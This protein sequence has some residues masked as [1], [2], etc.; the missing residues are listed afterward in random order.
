MSSDRTPLA[1]LRRDIDSIDDSMHDLLMRRAG[2]MDEIRRLKQG[3]GNMFFRPAREA[4]VL[5]RLLA[6]HRGA[7]PK[8]VLVRI[9]R[10]MMGALLCLQGPFAVALWEPEGGPG[11][12]AIAR[13]HFGSVTPITSHRSARA[14]INAVIENTVSVAVLPYPENDEPDPWWPLLADDAGWHVNVLGRLP[15]V[16]PETGGGAHPVALV[17][18]AATPEPTGSDHS[19]LLIDTVG[20]VSAMSLSAILR[21][22]DLAPCHLDTWTGTGDGQPPATLLLVDVADFV[23]SDDARLRRFTDEM[24]DVVRSISVAGAYASPLGAA[25]LA[26][27]PGEA[28]ETAP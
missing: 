13:D 22:V 19:L 12:R 17:V 20:T 5:R 6:R 14:A 28:K 8:P 18:G 11:Y 16:E 26:E 25:E 24:G 10:E 15:F 3:E 23:A 2:L 1:D 7:F 9:W 21:R 27:A 4:E